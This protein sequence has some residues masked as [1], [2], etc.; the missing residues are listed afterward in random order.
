MKRYFAGQANVNELVTSHA[1]PQIL[2]F[3]DDCHLCTEG[4]YDR[5]SEDSG[6]FLY[7]G[8]GWKGC[9]ASGVNHS[10][11]AQQGTAEPG[12]SDFPRA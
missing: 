4:Q 7:W 5:E 3:V 11:R 8:L 2:F 9:V 10:S 12:A 6:S 1:S